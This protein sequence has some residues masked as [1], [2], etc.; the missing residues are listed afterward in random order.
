MA[1]VPETMRHRRVSKE[2]KEA[3]PVTRVKSSGRINRRLEALQELF[4][5]SNPG[6]SVR[7]VYDPTHKPDLSNVL[8][9]TIDGFEMVYVKD[10]GEGAVQSLPG[11]KKEE[12]VRVGDTVMMSIAEAE[13][14]EMRAD[15]DRAAADEMTRVDQEFQ[16]SIEEITATKGGKTYSPRPLGTSV[17][18]EMERVV[19]GPESHSDT[20]D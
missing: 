10:L 1:E 14:K 11:L 18:E 6:R 7:W 13:R 19:E 15:L 20:Q 5:R 17:T 8:N 12:P 16:H 4:E 3:A 2:K 9:R